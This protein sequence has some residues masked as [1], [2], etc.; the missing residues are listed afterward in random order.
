MTGCVE[1]GTAGVLTI[2][3]HYWPQDLNQGETLAEVE[4]SVSPSGLT[5]VGLPG[6]S[7]SE[8]YQKVSGG[9]AGTDYVVQ[10]KVT[11]S[12]GQVFDHPYLD[13]FLVKVV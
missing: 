10:F 6:N 13:A 1:K 12:T 11:T 9:V 8:V 3:L 7:G 2:R 5:L 4:T